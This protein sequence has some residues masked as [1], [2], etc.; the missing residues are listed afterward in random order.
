MKSNE[1][2]DLILSIIIIAFL[3][4]MLLHHLFKGFFNLNPFYR[5]KSLEGFDTD[6]SGNAVSVEQTG[7]TQAEQVGQVQTEQ[8]QT[9]QVQTEQVGQVQ[10]GQVQAGQTQTEQTQ[11]G[12]VQTEQTQAGQVGQV[13]AGQ[14]QAGQTQAG[15]TQAGQTQAGQT[16]AVAID[17][18]VSDTDKSTLM[19]E[20]F[21]NVNKQMDIIRTIKLS[22]KLIP[23]KIDKTPLEAVLILANLKLLINNGIYKNELDLKEIYDKYIGNK[24][25]QLLTSDINSVKLETPHD[26]ISTLETKFLSRSKSIVD[27]HQKIIDK[28]LDNKSK[29]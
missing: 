21:E 20:L 13:Q 10:A 3:L 28:I 25:I 15:Q 22:D 12:Q 14:T 8:T 26:D 2:F 16:Q 27:A 6:A 17:I 11:T 24:A 7:Q 29:E 1:Y 19:A 23:I 4:F 18:T 9:G 5:N